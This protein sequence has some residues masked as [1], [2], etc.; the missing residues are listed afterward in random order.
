MGLL[1]GA[2]SMRRFRV[3][4]ALP[5]SWRDA[6]RDRLTEYAFRDPP[7]AAQKEEVE[8]WVRVQ[9]LLDTEFDD[10]NTWLFQQ[11]A[12]FAL[13]VDKKVLP[14]KLLK[15]Y[16]DKAARKWA[17]ERGV[18]RVPASVR[19]EIQ[20]KLETEWLARALPKVNVTELCWHVT[21]GWV[22]MA[23]A[24]DKVVDRVRKR[25]HRTFGL[26]LLPWSPL[27]AVTDRALREELLASAP[28]IGA[29]G[30]EA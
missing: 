28:T 20:D 4:G 12:V 21:D 17:A 10:F 5:D 26:E 22:V 2:L 13:R 9:N 23:G 27:D 24:S 6:I 1:S 3:E 16:V 11:H 14:G 8:G 30:G 19:K 29:A 25:F 18:E 7:V 15:A